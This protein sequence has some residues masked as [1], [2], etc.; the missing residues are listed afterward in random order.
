LKNYNILGLNVLVQKVCVQDV[1]LQY[2]NL[3]ENPP[4]VR[5]KDCQFAPILW[6]KEDLVI[7]EGLTNI[8]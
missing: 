7:L 4:Q 5:M 2:P 8:L 3:A 6:R 1:K